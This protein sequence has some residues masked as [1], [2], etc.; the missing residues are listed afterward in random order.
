MPRLRL[1]LRRFVAAVAASA[2]AAACGLVGGIEDITVVDE[3]SS[4][5]SVAI[6]GDEGPLRP[7]SPFSPDTATDSAVDAPV[8]TR[9]DALEPF[10]APVVVA[11]LNTTSD[12][13]TPRLSPDEL[14]VYFASTRPGHLG[15][16]SIYTAKRAARSDPFGAPALLPV[17]NVTNGT[18]YH[19][20][21]TGDGLRIF[22]QVTGGAPT[23]LYLGTRTTTAVEFS[24][25]APL[26]NV[27]SASFEFIPFIS[28]DGVHLLFSSNR[29]GA[30]LLYESAA[31]GGVF[32]AATLVPG[33]GSGN[34]AAVDT[35]PVLSGD[36]LSL[37]FASTRVD[38][39]S[40]SYDLFVARRT[41]PSGAFGTPTLVAE[42]NDANAAVSD[43]PSWLSA[44]ECRLYL[45]SDRLAPGGGFDV[46][47][48]TRTP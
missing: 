12:D 42:L 18:I 21:V 15:G 37:Y 41:T 36:L 48:A 3:Q 5:G 44:D 45:T 31:S 30:F 46:Y 25:P 9:C 40:S 28:A 29:S 47:L 6:P 35:A 34:G 38:P 2:A 27:N 4:D 10:G 32:P 24:T 43:V 22:L 33:V 7:D 20:A 13:S 14:T 16:G 11:S 8:K 23:D 26:A 39:G 17:V 19:P 1:R